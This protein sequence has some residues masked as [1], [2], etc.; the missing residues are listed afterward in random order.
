MSS[1]DSPSPG[2]WP[3]SKE[4]C[5]P[6]HKRISV[7]AQHKKLGSKSL[8]LLKEEV[9]RYAMDHTFKETAR[10]FG[11]HHSTVSGWVKKPNRSFHKPTREPEKSN[12]QHAVHAKADEVFISWLK[13]QRQNADSSG[14]RL[15]TLQSVKDKV[16][17]LMLE[18]GVATIEK[19]CKWFLLW[20]N[21]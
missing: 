18:F 8:S 12:L 21:R 7:I 3:S 5:D 11:I 13:Q 16:N 10:K 1:S 14:P 17:Q 9:R 15:I 6:G 2:L 4:N 19:S 20:N